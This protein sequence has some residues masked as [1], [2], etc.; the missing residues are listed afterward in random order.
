M[1]TTNTPRTRTMTTPLRRLRAFLAEA[2]SAAE[3]QPT[4]R[5]SGYPFADR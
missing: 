5:L 1:R 2:C 4:P 3:C